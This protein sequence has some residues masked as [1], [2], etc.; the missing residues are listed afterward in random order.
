MKKEELIKQIQE[1]VPNGAEVVVFDWRKNLSEDW[2]E[3]SSAGIYKEFDVEVHTA[4]EIKDGCIPF[5]S[6]TFNSDDYT[7]QGEK[8]E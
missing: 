1:K 4:E 2:G 5:A 3:G 6:I 7:D 8:L